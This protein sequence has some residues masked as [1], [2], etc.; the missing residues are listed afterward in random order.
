MARSS[1]LEQIQ[2]LNSTHQHHK[3]VIHS[4]ASH[5]ASYLFGVIDQ[6]IWLLSQDPNLSEVE[7]IL[8]PVG[9]LFTPRAL[10]G[11]VKARLKN[12]VKFLMANF[13]GVRTETTSQD[14]DK[15]PSLYQR[16]YEQRE[17][18]T[19]ETSLGSISIYLA[20]NLLGNDVSSWLR[21][22]WQA[23]QAW[24]QCY[25]NGDLAPQNLLSLK[26]RGVLIGD[27]IASTVLRSNP[28]SGG[29][30]LAC[31]K[32]ALFRT[33]VT[34]VF[35]NDYVWKHINGNLT[36]HCVTV[37]EPTY[38]HG[39]YKRVLHDRGGKVL[40]PHHYATE[41]KLIE[42][43]KPLPNPQ[44]AENSTTI[45][46][47]TFEKARS[48]TYLHERIHAP[49]KH[50]WY[51]FSGCNR[52]DNQLLN[53]DGMTIE[54][55][56]GKLYA[57]VFLHSFDDG[58]YWYGVDGF[59]DI[60][61]WTIFT[62]DNLLINSSVEK[63]LVKEHPNV[64]YSSYPGDKVARE[65]LQSRY[66]DHPKVGWLAKDCNPAA[67]S[68]SGCFIGIT[69]HGSIAEEL[70]FVGIP[71]IASNLAPWGKAYQFAQT[72]DNP[73]DYQSLL[74]NLRLETWTKPSE[75]M[76]EE[77]YKYVLDYR[78]DVPSIHQRAAWMKYAEFL[79]SKIPDINSV[80]YVSYT[81]KMA[82]LTCDDPRLI[83]FLN[84]LVKN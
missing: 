35:I 67:L 18:V 81:E 36:N 12:T 72:W 70:T 54:I 30:L 22:Y 77:L 45:Q 14:K 39:I 56:S 61:H 58:Q 79:T 28:E 23:I 4:T 69:H 43:N 71:V 68:N 64:N 75:T 76:L 5:G 62:I 15:I 32:L 16:V 38:L 59:D 9:G 60:Y 3:M 21:C 50:L 13:L 66:T 40:E 1:K 47:S 44:I 34:A 78:L 82:S 48:Q 63:V 29:S 57:V 11:R 46:L 52:T 17:R 20:P 74:Q 2:H 26:H 65:K 25:V 10:G 42:P 24:K 27:L 31:P 53:K 7:I 41:F 19:L 73:H 8:H 80:E 49:Q 6:A 84:T 33:L 51:M 37:P 55:A 83:N